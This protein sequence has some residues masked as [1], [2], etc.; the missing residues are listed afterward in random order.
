MHISKDLGLNSRSIKVSALTIMRKQQ[1]LELP[2]I[3][4][5]RIEKEMHSNG[6][7]EMTNYSKLRLKILMKAPK[8]LSIGRHKKIS[9][10]CLIL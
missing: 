8:E 3:K 5:L 7:R 1:S 10:I 4:F 9:Q 6:G 2:I